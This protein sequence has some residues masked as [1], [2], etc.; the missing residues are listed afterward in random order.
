MKLTCQYR[1]KDALLYTI[2]AITAFIGVQSM[3]NP[4]NNGTTNS[5]VT[6]TTYNETLYIGIQN[7][8]NTLLIESNATVAADN[9]V[10]GQLTSSTNNSV[11]VVG[12]SLLIA[13]DATTN[14]LTTGG[15]IVGGA[16]GGAAL[17]INN[18]STLDT[19]YL[20]VGF[21]TNDS[22]QIDLTGEGTKLTVAQD[23][24][25]GAAGSTN[26][27]EI[28]D[29]ANL[30]VG[31]TLTVGSVSS[32]NNHV[33]VAS[34]G[35]LFVNET[36]NI[37]VI[38]ADG[39]N[40]IVV[41][42]NGTLQVGGAVDTGTL[43]DQG[44]DLLANANL[45]LG[46][47]LTISQNKIDSR[48]NII[49][50]NDLYTNTASWT[51][52]SL[53]VI[54]STTSDNSLTFT[55]GATGLAWNIVQIGQQSTSARNELNI[56]GSNSLFRAILDVFVGAQG[57]DNQ[58]NISD[59]G[60]MLIGGS[61]YLGSDASATG[62]QVNINSNSVLNVGGDIVV[63]D[64]GGE[65]TFTMAGGQVDVTD[66]FIL[67]SGSI[68]NRYDQ[69]G[70]T[71][72]VAGA[73]IIGR[74][75]NATGKTG[76]VDNDRVETTGNLAIIG[77]NATLNVQQ[78]LTVGLEGGGSILTIRDGGAVNVDGDAVIGEAVGDNYIYLQRDSNTLFNV[79]GDIVVGKSEEGSNRLAVY[80]G[81]ANIGGNLYLG[82]TTNQHEIKNFIHVETTNAVI[83]VANA[84]YIGASN[85][86]NTLDLVDG[87]TVRALDLYVGT[88]EGV[89]NNVVTVTGES[90]LLYVTNI[91]EIGSSTGT[92]N[93][94]VVQN[95]GILHVDQTGIV[96]SGT[97]N[98]LEIADGGT[99]QA[100]DWDATMIDENIVFDTGST[101]ELGGSYLGTNRL[102]G[103]FELSLNGSL[104]TNNALWDTG[105]NTLYVGYV[106]DGNTL[107]AKEGGMIAT[108]TNL[109]VGRNEN[110][111]GN[112]LNSTGAGSLVDVGN[113]LTIGRNG[114]SNNTLTI[115][116]GGQ[117]DV[118]NS[119]IIGSS[120]G[121]NN[122]LISGL[123]NSVST[124]T[125]G[126]TLTIG[127]EEDATF[128]ALT[129]S[130]NATVTVSGI[131]TI[132]S[133]ASNNRMEITGTNAFLNAL[134]NFVIGAGDASG[135]EFNVTDGTAMVAGDL[136]IG[137]DVDSTDNTG[138]ITGSN[139]LIQVISDL[140]VGQD[141]SDNTLNIAD[142][143]VLEVLNAYVGFTTNSQFNTITVSGSNSTFSSSGTLYAGYEGSDNLVEVLDGASLTASNAYVGY[144]SSDNQLTV[145]GSNSAFTVLNDLF[146]GNT[147][148]N[149]SFNNEFGVFE[150][151]QASIGNNLSISNSVLFIDAGSQITVDGNYS[152]D[153]FS[154]LALRV[155]T[156]YA[157]TNLLVGNTGSFAKDTTFEIFDDDTVV[158]T[159]ND[160][161]RALVSAGTLEIDEQAATQDLLND[162]IVI[163]NDLL[164]FNLILSNNIIWIDNVTRLSLATASGLEPGTQLADVADEIDFMADSSNEV[165]V[166]MR[167]FMDT[168]LDSNGRNTAFHN[169]YDE[170]ISSSPAHS[171]INLGMQ[172]VAEQLTK[173]ADSTRARMGMA[174]ASSPEGAGG[175]HMAEQSMQGWVTGYKTWL[176]K[177]ADSGFDGYD[178]SIGGFL[179]G[180]DWSLAEGILVGI[181]GGAGNATLDKDNGASTDTDT[182]FGS[183]YM[184]AGTR[185]WFADA[186][187]IY[188]GSSIDTVLGSTFDTKASYDAKNT[189]IYVGGGK[190]I[191][192]NYL[193]FTPQ[194][195][196]LANYYKQDGYEEKS[197]NAVARKVDSFDALYLQS[198]IGCNVGFYTAMG[199]TIIKPEF[200]AFWVHE[201]NADEED[202][203]FQL[204]D[205]TGSYNMQLQAPESDIIKLGAGLTAKIGEYLELRADL[206]T[207]RGSNYSDH[208]LLGSIR[209]QF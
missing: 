151:A 105:S 159:T 106:E 14:G 32:S 19:E 78:G 130:S 18:A 140:Y 49:L 77:T 176:D 126:N 133:H 178:G 107:T 68:N 96:I 175:P 90:S 61:L 110:T 192:G 40:G 134:T 158:G 70:G 167:D 20:Y 3:A 185:D 45:E 21:G 36:N 147:D 104:A 199:E 4:F 124:L 184:S 27:I 165:A 58:L 50:N 194:A 118:G 125:I 191:I 143:G 57:K 112:E 37:V 74:T 117:V 25:V 205:G 155:S 87:A 202:V 48:L 128:N 65:N 56:G 62:N 101:L 29:G 9:I 64:S 156:N 98:N 26:S 22:G 123:S 71:N 93:S 129:V 103:F 69:I 179:I 10:I 111:T 114:S 15:V 119:L 142:G 122:A 1:R 89:S 11:S 7:P 54:G 83:N 75:T 193:T 42:G 63:G 141:G 181:A 132:G 173:R 182:T 208:T 120:S 59:G 23:A 94:V 190:E 8:N 146:I 44:V 108:A 53:T 161:A 34:G 137:K 60:Q 152:Q 135:N 188:G 95:G 157:T 138:S 209:Y 47:E 73:F 116:E 149:I 160:V 52:G 92:N 13:G 115:E 136:I 186:S 88:Y 172:S 196:L 55:N 102:D 91:F 131:A 17:S 127:M 84:L 5:I 67:G 30:S 148:T 169:Y 41:R 81:T 76:F 180:T 145:T 197:S 43:E 201:F 2:T 154:T 162:S 174:A 204:I 121:N 144:A 79:T 16:D 72:T 24:L 195:S 109:I 86:V 150:L 207:R 163:G 200:R 97:N 113:N 187:L 170:K 99:L 33:N 203:A 168:E 166:T 35:S 31:G 198:S 28:A 139:S 12:S 38:N 82:A 6:D 66:D 39:D 183:I 51:S 206:D 171:A 85:S 189:G 46:G 153:P 100:I 177:S 80:G 164:D